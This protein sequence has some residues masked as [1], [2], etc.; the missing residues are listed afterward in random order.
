[1]KKINKEDVWKDLS[2]RYDLTFVRSFI[3]NGAK[4]YLFGGAPRDIV[5][6]RK[7][8]DADF[9]ITIDLPPD[10]KDHRAEKIF[11][12]AK[13]SVQSKTDL[14][15]GMMIY[16]FKDVQSSEMV[17][18]RV[19]QD[20]W[21]G[22][23]D[24][25][26]NSLRLD[27]ETGDLIDR[28]NALEDIKSQVLRTAVPPKEVF[29]ENPFMIFRSV[30]AA[31]QLGFVLADDVKNA[32]TSFVHKIDICLDLVQKNENDFAEWVLSNMFVGLKSNPHKY[33]SLLEE[34]R[35]LKFLAESIANRLGT[36]SLVFNV[37][38]PFK[39]DEKYSYEAAISIF[40]SSVA[41]MLGD[42]EPEDTFNKILNLLNIKSPKRGDDFMVNKVEI[43]YYPI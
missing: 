36:K 1:M 29:A 23:T 5:M 4:V 17:D 28:F 33:F 31:C 9:C 38:N 26:V 11:E 37:P 8:K 22:G 7:W 6:G 3:G 20:M 40:I 27:L 2:K 41:R 16:R 10:E 30:K 24:F 12:L 14:G 18:V 13:I 15:H 21:S 43:K 35:A 19:V 32:M 25:T 42:Q 39:S 34:V